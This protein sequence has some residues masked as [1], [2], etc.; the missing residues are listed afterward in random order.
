MAA[1]IP[2]ATQAARLPRPGRNMRTPAI[3]PTTIPWAACHNPVCYQRGEQFMSPTAVSKKML[4]ETT[5][6]RQPLLQPKHGN[7]L[8]G[9]VPLSIDT[10]TPSGNFHV[11]V[12]TGGLLLVVGTDSGAAEEDDGDSGVLM[13][14]KAVE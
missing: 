4:V 12:K 8:Y 11:G 7:A 14:T 10:S 6:Q 5:E 2:A 1:P 3:P 13:V 9:N